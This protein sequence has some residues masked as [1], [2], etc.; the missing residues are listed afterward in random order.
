MQ[1][2]IL[3]FLPHGNIVKDGVLKS[4]VLEMTSF[5]QKSGYDCLVAAIC[6]EKDSKE[7]AEKNASSAESVERERVT[8]LFQGRP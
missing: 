5:L 6:S 3:F 8:A 4:Q 7:E 1:P 2:R